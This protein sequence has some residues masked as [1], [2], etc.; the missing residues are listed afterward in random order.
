MTKNE[1]HR[2]TS[3]SSGQI[4]IRM[5]LL[6]GLMTNLPFL[7]G[8]TMEDQ[9]CTTN[10][11]TTNRKEPGDHQS[12]PP[13][14]PVTTVLVTGANG[15]LGSHIVRTLLQQ[16]YIVHAGVRDAQN[17][18]KVDHL[19]E[20]VEDCEEPLSSPPGRRLQLFSTGDLG[21][22]VDHENPGKNVWDGPLQGVQAVIHTSL[23]MDWKDGLHGM[24]HPTLDGTRQLLE[25]IE[26]HRDT[27][28]SLVLTS[29]TAAVAVPSDG[30][31]ID[32]SH[33]NSATHEIAEG[34]W[35]SAT[36]IAQ[37]RLVTEW[38]EQRV[39]DGTLV[40]DFQF[41]SICPTRLLGP[42][43]SSRR[44]VDGWMSQ[45][46]QWR[47]HGPDLHSAVPNETIEF[48]HVEDVARMHVA[49][50]AEPDVMTGRFLC[51]GDSWHW[52]EFLQFLHPLSGPDTLPL[53]K[54]KDKVSPKRYS[55]KRRNTIPVNLR[56]MA[57][58]LEES[59]AYLATLQG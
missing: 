58:V 44:P 35:Y 18:A 57:T 54:R 23:A 30:S 43:V 14:H 24:Y 8:A 21:Q 19:L 46:Q 7:Q 20:M 34:S 49:V 59:I 16:N 27:V 26:R 11:D 9:T 29:S 41:V 25:A 28:R 37:E 48:V 32:E 4:L 50:L 40:S 13:P 3:T 12:Q 45:L 53:Y 6:V 47:R 55:T 10:D 33:W 15:Y 1:V 38:V 22:S 52:N 36:K 2:R 5:I 31:M 39:M 42:P 51:V 56:P 17:L